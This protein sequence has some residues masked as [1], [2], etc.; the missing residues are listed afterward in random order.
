MD[1]LKLDQAKRGYENVLVV[2]DHFTRYVQ[3]YATKHKSAKSAA[4]KL[5]NNKEFHNSLFQRLHQLFEIKSRK[6]TPYHPMGTSRH[7]K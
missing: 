2:A 6:T 5:H 3:A 4:N 1:S 7:E